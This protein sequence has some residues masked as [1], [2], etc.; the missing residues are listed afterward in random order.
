MSAAHIA[1]INLECTDPVTLARFWAGL[2]DSEV[3]VETPGFCA[4]KAGPLYLGAVRVADHRPPTWPS[5][6]RPQQLHLDLA[7]EDLDTTEREAIRL[8][9]TKETHQPDP[10]RFRVLR[11]PA[12]HPF[13]L[14]A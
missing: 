14:R 9:A 8:G 6:E 10:E 3:A 1:A 4:V 2:L 12:G 13:C 11:D 7:V 5:A